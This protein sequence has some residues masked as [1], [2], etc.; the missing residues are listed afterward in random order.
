MK[1]RSLF[2]VAYLMVVGPSCASDGGSSSV[3][4]AVSDARRFIT[5]RNAAGLLTLISRDGVLCGDDVISR[6]RVNSDL[7]R[8]ITPLYK[9][10]FGD[11][12]RAASELSLRG[13][14]VGHPTATPRIDFIQVDGKVRDD[15]A[16]VR[17]RDENSTSPFEL[18]FFR[19][20]RRWTLTNSL[21]D[22]E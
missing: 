6:A 2:F 19:K 3:Q 12:S 14:F 16:C 22:C 21:Y 4:S 10:V 8:P 7:R 5:E 17:F 15:W 20:Q 9:R 1:Y 11:S 13:W 18:C